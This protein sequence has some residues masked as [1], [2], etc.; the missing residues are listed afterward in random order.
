MSTESP[1]Q[2][3]PKPP[4]KTRLLSSGL[5]VSGMTMLSRVAGLVRDIVLAVV[6]GGMASGGTASAFYIAFKV[7][8]FL[9]RLFAEGAFSQAFVPVLSEYQETTS[10]QEVQNLINRVAG[11]LTLILL[12]VVALV[13]IGSPVVTYMVAPGFADDPEKFQLTETLIS[14]TFPYL[15]FISLAG[16]LGAILNANN[17]FAA[18]AFAPVLLNICLIAAGLYFTDY[19]PNP[20]MALAYGVIIAGVIQLCFLFPFVHKIGFFPRPVID[21]S[22]PGV[23]KVLALMLPA[24]L[25]VSVAQI[26]LVFDTILASFLPEGSIPWLYYSQR[27][28]D[29]PLGVF[30]IAIST[31]I[32][33]GLSRAFAS[34]NTDSFAPTLDWAVRFVLMISIPAVL[35]FWVLAIPIMSTLFYHGSVMT[36]DD[37]RMMRLSLCAYALGL[38]FFMLIKVLVPGYYARQDMKT[39]VKI[40]IRAMIANMILNVLFVVPMHMYLQWGHMGLALATAVSAMLN[41]YW[42]WSGLRKEG[43]YQVQPGFYKQAILFLIAGLCMVAV[44]LGFIHFFPN[45]FDYTVMQ[46]II[47]LA[48]CT[49]A[50][51]AVY[52]AVLFIGGVRIH[53]FKQKI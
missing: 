3:A 10:K 7:P 28:S 19:F 36:P 48:A 17:R 49:L 52:F 27:L 25:G 53:D 9:R 13:I 31:V 41:V 44:L 1:A 35:A 6:L 24:L 15:L 47:Y 39:P 43:I 11:G 2:S 23:K 5:L 38:P 8:Q 4:K 40:A 29:L 20:A 16:F 30:A 46:R 32:L 51:I 42:L 34:K 21:F 45:W 22:H 37:I 26:N 12:I 14:I 18:P 33:P 50:G